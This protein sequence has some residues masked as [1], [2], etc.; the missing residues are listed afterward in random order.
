MSEWCRLPRAA[1]QF[2]CWIYDWQTLLAGVLAVLA[3]VIGSVLLWRQIRLSKEQEAERR[4]RRFNAARATMPLL[5][6]GIC[7]YARDI[8]SVLRSIHRSAGQYAFG[9]DSLINNAPALPG[10]LTPALERLIE[11]TGDDEL[12]KHIADLLSQIQIINARISEIPRLSPAAGGLQLMIEDYMIQAASIYAAASSLF[13]FARREAP[14][15]ASSERMEVRSALNLL[16]IRDSE[17]ERVHET[18]RR[19]EARIGPRLSDCIIPP[20]PSP[21]S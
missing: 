16:E 7:A 10:E 2:S 11:S 4:R 3:A 9:A 12:A 18:A 8:A 17:F 1:S 15:L 20:G 5:L 14:D 6:S 13:G 21:L 19:R